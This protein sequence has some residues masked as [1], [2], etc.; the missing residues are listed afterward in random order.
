LILKSLIAYFISK[1]QD[2][3]RLFAISFF[4]AH[5]FLAVFLESFQFTEYAFEELSFEV[6]V[7]VEF[8]LQEARTPTMVIDKNNTIFIINNL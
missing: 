6:H 3:P 8:F 4:S 7:Q 1:I 2:S 5:Q